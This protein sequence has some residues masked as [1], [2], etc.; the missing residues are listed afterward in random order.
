MLK[1]WA[2]VIMFNK[3]IRDEFKAFTTRGD[4][5]SLGVCNGCQVMA[6]LGWIP[7]DG[8]D[9][10]KQ[11]RFVRNKSGIFES[12]FITVKIYPSPS[13]LLKGMEGS[14]LGVWVW[15]VDG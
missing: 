6:L 10:D 14:V 15:G 13:I 4:T 9:I 3:K 5:F 8:I 12:R 2:G 1:G 11:P 7:W